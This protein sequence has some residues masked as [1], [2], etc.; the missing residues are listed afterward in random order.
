V[1]YDPYKW[2]YHQNFDFKNATPEQKEVLARE[3][4][5]CS[6]YFSA[7]SRVYQANSYRGAVWSPPFCSSP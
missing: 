4:A 5:H 6:R 2:E 1:P 3:N 7:L